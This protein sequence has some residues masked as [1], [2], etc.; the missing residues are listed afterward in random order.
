MIYKMVSNTETLTA[1]YH[2]SI[3]KMLSFYRQV[4]VIKNRFEKQFENLFKITRVKLCLKG[5]LK[6]VAINNLCILLFA[7]ARMWNTMSLS[8]PVPRICE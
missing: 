6:A 4:T 8:R 3:S 2:F 5:S 1:E 7:Q